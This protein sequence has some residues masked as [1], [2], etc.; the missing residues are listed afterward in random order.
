MFNISTVNLINMLFIAGGIGVCGL[1]FLHISSSVHLRKEVRRYFQ[2][3]FSV[4]V[5]Y[6]TSHLA[7]QIMEGLP[8]DGVKVA[9]YAVTFVEVLA[10]GFM[11]FLISSV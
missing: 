5:L 6:I 11:A 1:C 8:G 4:I 2:A 3:F 7:R 10:A 9:L